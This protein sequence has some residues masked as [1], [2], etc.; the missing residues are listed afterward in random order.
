MSFVSDLFGGAPSVSTEAPEDLEAE[1]KKNERARRR[2]LATQ[3]DRI[4][5]EVMAGET[6]QRPSILGN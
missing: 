1:K 2:L 5:E 6:T 3:G 4:G